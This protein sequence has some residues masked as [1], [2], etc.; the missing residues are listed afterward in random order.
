M[1]YVSFTRAAEGIDACRVWKR[2]FV[3]RLMLV[4]L[5]TLGGETVFCA[6]PFWVNITTQRPQKMRGTQQTPRTTIPNKTI[7]AQSLAL[8]TFG[9]FRLLALPQIPV[10]VLIAVA[11]LFS[12][13]KNKSGSYCDVR[14]TF[15]YHMTYMIIT[16]IKADGIFIYLFFYLLLF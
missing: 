6:S 11:F 14:N 10:N 3:V 12:R 13:P 1:L 5:S 4:S 2:D 15:L 8:P 7:S 9:P 16:K